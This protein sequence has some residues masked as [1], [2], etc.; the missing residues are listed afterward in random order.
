MSKKMTL[1]EKLHSRSLEKPNPVLYWILMLV[2]K[3]WNAIIHTTFTCKANPADEEGSFVLISNHATRNDYLFTAPVCLPQ[4]LNYVVGYNEFLRFPL[5]IVLKLMQ[6]VPKKNFTPVIYCVK[7]IMGIK[8]IN[9][10]VTEQEAV[11]IVDKGL[12]RREDIYGFMQ[13]PRTGPG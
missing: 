12:R 4:R 3:I 9:M 5:N 8:T 13:R 1:E 7:Q 2:I 10:L 6:A 11:I